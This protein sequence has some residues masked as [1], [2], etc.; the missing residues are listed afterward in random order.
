[1]GESIPKEAADWRPDGTTDA[2][3][4]LDGNNLLP[5]KAAPFKQKQQETHHIPG[6]A[7]EDALPYQT[8]ECGDSGDSTDYLAKCHRLLIVVFVEFTLAI[9][10]AG[11]SQKALG[12]CCRN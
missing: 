9:V 11:Y 5:R 1:M 10:M 6:Y 3:S 7:T 8:K 2:L 4:E 12:E